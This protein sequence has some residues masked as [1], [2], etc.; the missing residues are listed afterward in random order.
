MVSYI[1]QSEYKFL[2]NFW[3][4]WKVNTMRSHLFNLVSLKNVAFSWNTSMR[5]NLR[6]LDENDTFNFHCAPSSWRLISWVSRL[7]LVQHELFLV[8]GSASHNIKHSLDSQAHYCWPQLP[9]LW[10]LFYRCGPVFCPP[11]CQL[12][13]LL[14]GWKKIGQLL[15]SQPHYYILSE[16][17]DWF[18]EQ[19]QL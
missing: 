3:N 12:L 1:D 11:L 2:T 4:R 7:Q 9:D 10:D 13:R 6:Y 17:Y 18:Q 16:V 14:Q 8:I 19:K 15:L 5:V